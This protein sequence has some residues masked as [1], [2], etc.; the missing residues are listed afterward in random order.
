MLVIY[1]VFQGLFKPSARAF[2]LL[3]SSWFDI[4]QFYLK[5]FFCRSFFTCESFPQRRYG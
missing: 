4:R 3:G 1:I 5:G 2:F